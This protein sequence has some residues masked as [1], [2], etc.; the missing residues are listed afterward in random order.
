MYLQNRVINVCFSE[1]PQ[2][3]WQSRNYSKYVALC[4]GGFEI[5]RNS[6]TQDF[7]NVLQIYFD[8]CACKVQMVYEKSLF[9]LH[10]AY[11]NS[12]VC[13][14]YEIIQKKNFIL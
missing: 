9:V 2:G 4:W 14:Q 11:W 1:Q 7:K 13:N 5:I 12:Q 6:I 8:K 10:I 3:V